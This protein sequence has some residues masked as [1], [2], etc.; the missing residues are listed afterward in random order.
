MKKS[1]LAVIISMF[2]STSTSVAE[3]SPGTI[4]DPPVAQQN[5]DMSQWKRLL[6][7]NNYRSLINDKSSF[8]V[9]P[10]GNKNYLG[11]LKV[12]LK[13]AGDDP[14]YKCHF[15]ARYYFLTGKEDFQNCEEYRK[16]RKY[17]GLDKVSVVYASEDA[18][19][20]VS[21]LG[22]LLIKFEGY[23]GQNAYKQYGLGFVANTTSDAVLLLN[24]FRGSIDGE[25]TL[26]PYDDVIVNYVNKENRSIW[27]YELKL[28]PEE[29]KLLKYHIFELKSHVIRYY[30]TSNNCTTGTSLILSVANEKYLYN[31]NKF[32]VTP[33]E[34][35]QYLHRQNAIKQIILLPSASQKDALRKNRIANP[36]ESHAPFRTQLSY[37]YSSYGKNGY[38]LRVSPVLSNL[39][40]NDNSTYLLAESAFADVQIA[41][42]NNRT[43]LRNIDFI[44]LKHI[45]DNELGTSFTLSFHGHYNTASTILKPDVEFLKNYGINY[46]NILFYGAAGG[47]Y[48]LDN[49]NTIYGKVE[50]GL[51]WQSNEPWRLSGSISHYLSSAHQYAGY[52]TGI[53]L[54]FS[55]ELFKDFLLNTSFRYY[56]NNH[57]HDYETSA[58]FVWYF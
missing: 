9:T 45:P 55:G 17:T 36:L 49:K 2:S 4:I 35:L 52:K 20:P 13:Q 40:D 43:Y 1:L 29:K 7:Y 28:T 48:Y 14:D 6:H 23:N 44:R 39:L 41:Y 46:E 51:I 8:F 18:S 58:G 47:G 57:N 19:S 27:E 10:D 38:L 50:Y 24:F 11:E 30:F 34:Y 22:H 12:N 25:H 16:Y 54:N 42:Q 15:P 5:F 56:K 32:F 37:I 33:K 53:N 26:Q 3:T 31:G 21:S